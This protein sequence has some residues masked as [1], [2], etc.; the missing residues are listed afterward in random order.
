MSETIEELDIEAQV[1][2]WVVWHDGLRPLWDTDGP[3]VFTDYQ[4][5]QAA[6]RLLDVVSP[7]TQARYDELR[8]QFDPG[9]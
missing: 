8:R 2:G 3:K 9:R 1:I 7:M 5:A 6:R 4:E